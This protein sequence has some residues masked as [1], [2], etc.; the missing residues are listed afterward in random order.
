[1]D[2]A[3][4]QARKVIETLPDSATWD[5]IMYKIYVT[6]KI[7]KGLDDCQNGNVVSHGEVKKQFSSE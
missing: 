6:Q 3:K 7:N 4:E 5:D 2:I 1:M